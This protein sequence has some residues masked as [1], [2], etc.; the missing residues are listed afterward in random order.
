[1]KTFIQ[2]HLLIGALAALLLMAATPVASAQTPPPREQLLSLVPDDVA[3]CLLVTDL[4]EQ[5]DKLMQSPWIKSLKDSP[6]G[7]V[8]GDAPELMKLANVRKQIQKHLQVDWN[9]LRDEILGDAVVLAYRPALPDHPENEGG[10]LLLHARNPD[11]LKKLMDRLN[12]E[13]LKSGE[14]KAV[15][16]GTFKGMSYVERVEPA[17]SQYYVLDGPL[18]AFSGQMGMMQRLLER[19]ANAKAKTL[20]V[21]AQLR[22]VGCDKALVSVW[23]NPRAFDSILE[24]QAAELGAKPEGKSLKNFLSYWKALDGVSLSLLVNKNPE[25]VLSM[26]AHPALLP[27]A[28]RKLVLESGKPSELWSR[29]PADSAITV[30]AR[31]DMQALI[32]T[33][34]QLLPGETEQGL[35]DFLQGALGLPVD[36][37][38]LEALAPSIGP[39]WGFSVAAPAAKDD[40][41]HVLFALRLRTEPDGP[42]LYKSLKLLAVAAIGDY[43]RKHKDQIKLETMQQ[44]GAEVQYLTNAKFPKGFRP[45][46]GSRDGYLLIGSSPEALQRFGKAGSP[47]PEGSKAP[48]A[49]IAFAKLSSL[50]KDRRDGVIGLL[51]KKHQLSPQA[52][53]KRF[54]QLTWTLDLFDTA[55]LVQQGSGESVAWVFR[56]RTSEK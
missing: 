1:M 43:N 40:F 55:E 15:K 18:L 28:A 36:K 50:L 45:A 10:L 25:L 19:R 11:L 13:Q 9:Q 39:D 29:L 16:A 51:A 41:P 38:F 46:F 7:Q 14:L 52:A 30:A 54:E 26:H 32:Q 20:P 33:L 21:L 2:R 31:T 17:G 44:N 3:V 4:R 34:D 27:D 53:A 56:L 37:E 48:L 49:R 6:F 42:D 23:I 22:E 47:P 24:A 5:G 12:Q 35:T 8:L